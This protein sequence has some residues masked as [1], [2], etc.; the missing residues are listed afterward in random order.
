MARSRLESELS[1]PFYRQGARLREAK[2]A[3]I[4]SVLFPEVDSSASLRF[5]H[6]G[7]KGEGPSSTQ[8]QGPLS[9]SPAGAL[10]GR[11][12]VPPSR[13]PF[14][15]VA[16][17]PRWTLGG[18]D[19]PPCLQG[20]SVGELPRHVHL[21]RPPEAGPCR[22]RGCG[23]PSSTAQ[24]QRKHRAGGRRG[25]LRPTKPALGAQELHFVRVTSDPGDSSP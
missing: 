9:G 1:A 10:P 22:P 16:G 23:H 13:L 5:T 20:S 17:W 7:G 21:C 6:R 2:A 11:V 14:L 15:H 24:L 19:C 18:P 4:L 8:P 12:L 25:L 3:Q